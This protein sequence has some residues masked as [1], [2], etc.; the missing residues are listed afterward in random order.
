VSGYEFVL[1]I[2]LLF[3]YVWALIAI[4]VTAAVVAYFVHTL[5]KD[6]K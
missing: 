2:G 5:F 4:T 1:T 3:V 6:M